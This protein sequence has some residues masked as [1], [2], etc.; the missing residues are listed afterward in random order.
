[1]IK[2]QFKNFDKVLEQNGVLNFSNEDAFL[3]V[4]DVANGIL[5]KAKKV[6]PF[7]KNPKRN[8]AGRLHDSLK[9]LYYEKNLTVSFESNHP[10]AE[11]VEYGRKYTPGKPSANEAFPVNRS[12]NRTVHYH[13]MWEAM[14]AIKK[15]IST[16]FRQRVKAKKTGPDRY[17]RRNAKMSEIIRGR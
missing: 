4:Q 15:K 1:M 11:S 17:D 6:L 10:G 8:K 7:N 5:D 9:N 13:Y 14:I 3:L 2:I 16:I 12:D